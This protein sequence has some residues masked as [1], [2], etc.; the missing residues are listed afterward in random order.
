MFALLLTLLTQAAPLPEPCEPTNKKGWTHSFAPS[1]CSFLEY[2]EEVYTATW[3]G[4]LSTKPAAQQVA[5]YRDADNRWHIRMAGYRWGGEN[6]ATVTRQRE[7]TLTKGE[8]EPIQ[9]S[10][11]L[12]KIEELAKLPVYGQEARLCLDGASLE[13]TYAKNGRMASVWRHSCSDDFSIDELT[14]KF[15]TLALLKD[16]EFEG[17]LRGISRTK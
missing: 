17:L 14:A 10:V 11:T 12:E 3:R 5:I 1:A 7:M 2:A 13:L 8:A 9:Q 15:R 4:S 6:E 16:P